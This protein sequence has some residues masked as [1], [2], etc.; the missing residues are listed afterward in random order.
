MAEQG[1]MDKAKNFVTD[2]ISNV[3]KPEA[4]VTDVD[5]KK[6]GLSHVEY[7]SKVSVTNPYSHS[8]PICDIKYTLK[9]VNRVIASGTI[10]DPG[11]LKASD[12]TVLE[13]LL[14]VPHSILVTLAKDLGADW[15]F[16]YELDI[17]L[18]IDL[19]V[20]GNFTIPLNKKGEFKLPTLF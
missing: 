15:D 12:I 8:I 17:G 3:A 6:M 9:S 20:I 4:E 11:S 13:V 1:F 18:T 7:L 10:P 5:F 16:D 2:K 19:P 14:K